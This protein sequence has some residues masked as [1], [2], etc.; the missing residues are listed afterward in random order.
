MTMGEA[1]GCIA[2][3]TCVDLRLRPAGELCLSHALE[4]SGEMTV[5]YALCGLAAAADTD[6]DRS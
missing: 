4:S 5:L 6:I 3:Q 2:P 1:S